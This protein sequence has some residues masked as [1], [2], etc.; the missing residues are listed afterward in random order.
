[1]NRSLRHL[2]VAGSKVTGSFSPIILAGINTAKSTTVLFRTFFSKV[3]ISLALPQ[4]EAIV[5]KNQCRSLANVELRSPSGD[6]SFTVRA[7]AVS[8]SAVSI[9]VLGTIWPLHALN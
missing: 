1:M 7:V 2:F 3:F 4:N 6:V 9:V 5:R 8:A